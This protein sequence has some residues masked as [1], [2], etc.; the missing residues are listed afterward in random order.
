MGSFK[1][2][3]EYGTTLD[4]GWFYIDKLFG[5]YKKIYEEMKERTYEHWN[6]REFSKYILEKSIK[7]KVTNYAIRNFYG[8]GEDEK[9]FGEK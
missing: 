5:E 4:L 9:F 7:G 6:G 3:Y 2:F 8:I 1:G